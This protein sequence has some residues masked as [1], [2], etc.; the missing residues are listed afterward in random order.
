MLCFRVTWFSSLTWF[1]QSRAPVLRRPSPAGGKI[2]QPSHH[3]NCDNMCRYYFVRQ[4]SSKE[5]PLHSLLNTGEQRHHSES[6]SRH[7]NL[8]IGKLLLFPPIPLAT[9]LRQ[10]LQIHRYSTDPRL[11]RVGSPEISQRSSLS[12][13]TSPAFF[14]LPRGPGIFLLSFSSQRGYGYVNG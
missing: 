8:V 7:G 1:P 5:T 14:A 3:I 4:S 11:S 2:N 10:P 12:T 9:K 6:R 13:S